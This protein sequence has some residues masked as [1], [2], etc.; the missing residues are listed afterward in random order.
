LADATLHIKSRG[1]YT[2]PGHARDF[3]WSAVGISG[4]RFGTAL[5]ESRSACAM[6]A[7]QEWPGKLVEL[8]SIRSW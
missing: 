6:T 5:A 2:A 3:A 4:A 8:E 1:S 7:T